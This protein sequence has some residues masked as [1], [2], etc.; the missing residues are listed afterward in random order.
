MM[1][2]KALPFAIIVILIC[3]E[4]VMH[5]NVFKTDLVGFHVWRQ[6]ETQTVI[7]NMAAGDGSLFVP[8]VN[9]MAYENRS[10][11]KEFPLM[12]WIFAQV[13]NLTGSE[14][15]SSRALSFFIGIGTLIFI[16][17]WFKILLKNTLLSALGSWC[18]G[19][20]PSFYY[21]MIC[22][23]PDNLALLLGVA[24]LWTASCW[25]QNR[26]PGYLL[27]TAFFLGL[28]TL[29]KLPFILFFVY[30]GILLIQVSARKRDISGFLINA[31]VLLAGLLPALIWYAT[32]IPTWQ[33]NGIV[34]GAFGSDFSMREWLGYL[35]HNIVSVLPELVLN[36]GSLLF[37]IVG[38]YVIARRIGHNS[39]FFW[40]LFWT[41]LSTIAYFLFELNMI[42]DVHDYYLF[43]M[44]PFIFLIVGIGMKSLWMKPALKWRILSLLF[45]AIL[46]LLA[47]L[48]IQQR[49]NLE[50]NPGFNAVFLEHKET[51]RSIIPKDALVITGND[52][53]TFIHLYY[54]DRKG[55][56][57]A[58]NN[59]N[60]T[61]LDSLIDLGA[62]FL[63]SD[64]P[65]IWNNP[66]IQMHF[67]EQ[68]WD[69]PMLRVYTL[70]KQ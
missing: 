27:I 2:G 53:S 1:S 21:Y 59:L 9:N 43:P 22:P 24:G 66:A 4:F 14:I 29:V 38:L 20:S 63:V 3:A 36:Y 33:G 45:I 65:E 7:N 49:W 64:S 13:Q 48:R 61:N 60:N 70:Q 41:G 17:L 68:V 40:P 23:L 52:Y 55:W 69:H 47:F 57:F 6:T 19:F 10:L 37:F 42:K 25:Y 46:P 51:L 67:K 18:F 30:P 32:V 62:K 44:F 31:L 16:F 5:F 39:D 11:R 34:Q 58:E 15:A 8:R 12:Q 26:S 50:K 54:L 56:V 35:S 28:S